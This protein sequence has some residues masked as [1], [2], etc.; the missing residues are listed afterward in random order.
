MAS[1]AVKT[2]SHPSKRLDKDLS[3]S[4]QDAEKKLAQHSPLSQREAKELHKLFNVSYQLA[5]KVTSGNLPVENHQEAESWFGSL[6][7]V[8]K[9]YGPLLLE[10]A[11]LLLGL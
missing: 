4:T 8:V 1:K 10:V 6:M 11:P 3:R 2:K 7:E 9:E 5:N